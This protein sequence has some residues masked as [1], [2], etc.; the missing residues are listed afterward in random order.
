M[1]LGEIKVEALRVIGANLSEDLSAESMDE[2]LKTEKYRSYLVNMVGP[3]NRCLSIL[4]RRGM[5]DKPIRVSGGDNDS[6]ELSEL[7][8]SDELA[9]LIPFYI[10]YELCGADDP[11]LAAQAFALFERLLGEVMAHNG[12]RQERV[13]DVMGG[14]K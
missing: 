14:L 4:L 11:D 10:K 13:E 6:L 7:G 9:E 1:T 2:L 5:L 3:I 8:L 12:K